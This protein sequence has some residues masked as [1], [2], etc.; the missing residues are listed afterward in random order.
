MPDISQAEKSQVTPHKYKHSL[1]SIIK[2]ATISPPRT[3]GNEIDVEKD[4]E[5][6][7]NA[8]GVAVDPTTLDPRIAQGLTPT[9]NPTK[10]LN[11]PPPLAFAYLKVPV[12]IYFFLFSFFPP[13]NMFFPFFLTSFRH[14]QKGK[15][16]KWPASGCESCWGVWKIGQ[17]IID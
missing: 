8:K 9:R 14:C 10:V 1:Q 6:M 2:Q 4:E 11:L 13:L 17:E 5:D 16:R 15:E 3:N 7:E 12:N